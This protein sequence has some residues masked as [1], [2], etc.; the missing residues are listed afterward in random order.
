MIAT[1]AKPFTLGVDTVQKLG[2]KECEA[3]KA[4]GFRFV[5]RYLGSVSV[6]E[7]AAILAA[8]LAFMPVTY[9]KNYNGGSAV[10]DL[11]ALSI[12]AGATVWLDLEGETSAPADLIAKI[13][14]W[15]SQIEGAGYEPGLYVGAGCVLTSEE[16]FALRVK[17][18]WNSCSREVDRNGK[19]ANPACD[20]CMDQLRPYNCGRDGV[21]YAVP[22]VVVDVDVI[23]QDNKG[24]LPS[25]VVA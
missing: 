11:R 6:L 4:A 13:N 3:I 21:P 9:A 12:P 16:L 23:Q 14:A 18:Y 2:S 10:H 7:L 8:G 22:G 19:V 1:T 24:R 5:V 17:R 20:Y 25:W 15:A